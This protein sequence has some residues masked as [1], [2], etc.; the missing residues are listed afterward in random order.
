MI[1]VLREFIR[2]TRGEAKGADGEA[3][4]ADGEAKGAD[5][6]ADGRL[7]KLVRKAWYKADDCDNRDG[8]TTQDREDLCAKRK[9]CEVFRETDV[10]QRTIDAAQR[11]AALANFQLAAGSRQFKLS[12]RNHASIRK[13]YRQALEDVSLQVKRFATI[14]LRPCR[15]RKNRNLVP[16]FDKAG[17]PAGHIGLACEETSGNDWIEAYHLPYRCTSRA[18][19]LGGLPF[20]LISGREGV[21]M[22]Q[23]CFACPPLSNQRH[24]SRMCGVHPA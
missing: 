13:Q 7:A 1:T 8:G 11:L 23:G 18:C 19:C 21:T 5:G 16:E 20:C 10:G 12:C 3:K 14:T 17:A 15:D 6:D 22:C 4:G 9:S 24:P 2:C